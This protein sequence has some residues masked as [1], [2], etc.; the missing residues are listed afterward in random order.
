MD[1][2]ERKTISEL[3]P[4]LSKEIFADDVA[5]HLLINNGIE[6]TQYQKILNQQMDEDRRLMLL[7]IIQRIDGGWT[8]LCNALSACQQK[9]LKVQLELKLVNSNKNPI[10]DSSG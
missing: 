1:Q 7:E 9:Y 2:H 5:R 8:K 4:I 6:K 10:V 3:L